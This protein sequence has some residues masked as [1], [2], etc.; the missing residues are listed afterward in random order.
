MKCPICKNENNDEAIVCKICGFSEL[1]VEFLNKEDAERWKETVLQQCRNIYQTLSK[2]VNQFDGYP[3]AEFDYPRRGCNVKIVDHQ[4]PDEYFGSIVYAD[5][6]EIHIQIPGKMKALKFAFNK[7]MPERE[8]ERITALGYVVIQRDQISY[9]ADEVY[10]EAIEG[11]EDVSKFSRDKTP[12]AEPYR[13]SYDAFVKRYIN[14]RSWCF[15]EDV[16]FYNEA[17]QKANTYFCA[18][19]NPPFEIVNTRVSKNGA[20]YRVEVCLRNVSKER[21]NQPIKFRYRIGTPT[22]NNVHDWTDTITP[23]PQYTT[24]VITFAYDGTDKPYFEIIN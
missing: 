16:I 19:D 14:S 20:H 22:M 13:E 5:R 2:K 11:E 18:Y 21:R 24:A 17:Y 1:N 12:K 8:I 7:G 6:Y 10:K 4:A 3:L 9:V 23:A 15:T